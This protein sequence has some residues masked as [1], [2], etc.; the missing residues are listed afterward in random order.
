MER[1]KKIIS[2]R[3]FDGDFPDHQIEENTSS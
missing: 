1:W 3:N 2:Q